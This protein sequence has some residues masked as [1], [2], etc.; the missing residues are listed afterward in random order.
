MK[1]IICYGRPDEIRLEMSRSLKSNAKQREK[2]SNDI[3]KNERENK[4]I[5]EDIEKRIWFKICQSQ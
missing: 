3:R 4:D 5:D 2:M 1:I